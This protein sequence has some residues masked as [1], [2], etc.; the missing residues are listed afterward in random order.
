MD[1][2]I[3]DVTGSQSNMLWRLS[4]HIMSLKYKTKLREGEREKNGKETEISEKKKYVHSVSVFSYV[5][6]W[7]GAVSRVFR[8]T[9]AFWSERF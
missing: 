7:W 6:A 5:N 8:V 3:W 2:L 4:A 9:E 1:T